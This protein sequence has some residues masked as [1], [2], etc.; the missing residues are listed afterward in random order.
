M[1]IRFS[2]IQIFQIAEAL[3]MH[4]PPDKFDLFAAST[5]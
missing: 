4:I 2:E 3:P 5:E 1:K